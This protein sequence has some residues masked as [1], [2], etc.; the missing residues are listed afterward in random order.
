MLLLY[1][2]F[3]IYIYAFRLSLNVLIINKS[4]E[5]T[6]IQITFHVRERTIIINIFKF[7][8]LFSALELLKLDFLYNIDYG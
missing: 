6:K 5:E 3:D 1:L 8:G 2:N 7:W 4:H